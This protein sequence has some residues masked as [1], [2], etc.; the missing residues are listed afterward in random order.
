MTSSWKKA[1]ADVWL[2]RT[3]TIMVIIAIAL[4]VTGFTTV[5]SSY[6]ILMRELNDDFLATNPASATL[7][8]DKVDEALLTAIRRDPQVGMAEPRRVVM[9]KIKTGPAEWKTVEL[10]VI[11]DFK[12]IQV[13]TIQPEQG[14]WPPASGEVLIERDAF[15]VA[16]TRIGEQVTLEMS[17]GQEHTLLVSGGVHDVGQAQARMDAIVYAYITVDTLATLG[18][19][20]YLN[21]LNIV[22]AHDPFDR[23]H[24]RDVATA[25]GLTMTKMGHPVLK[26][27]V[28]VPGEHPH[29]QIMG[30]LLLV[31]AGFGILVLLLSGVLVVNLLMALMAAQIRQIGVMKAI[32]GSRWQIA[33][34]YFCQ[35]LFLGLVSL[36][37]AVPLGLWS[38]RVLCRYLGKF[39][40][41]DINSYAVP[42][43]VFMLI[44]AI[45]IV[46]PL[47][48][49]AYPI[50]KAC[51]ISVHDALYDF[52]VVKNHYKSNWF[53]QLLATIF[54]TRPAVLYT[55]RNAF[56]R[57]TRLILTLTTLTV[58]GVFFM[59]A[60]NI[61]TSII[62]TLDHLFA[63][64]D[65]DLTVTLVDM[66][67]SDAIQTALRSTAGI[68]RAETWV[69]ANGNYG[70]P[71]NDNTPE[72]HKFTVFGLPEQSQ[73]FKPTIVEGRH[74]LPGETDAIV[75]NHVVA[76]NIAAIKVGATIKLRIGSDKLGYRENAWRVV[77][78]AREPFSTPAV[79][80]PKNYF[81][82]SYPAMGN[83]VNMALTSTDAT[84]INSV[85]A[86]LE[87]NLQ[88]QGI[89][90]RG[91]FTKEKGRAVIDEHMLM[92]YVF[93]I[94]MACIIAGVGG[95][96][97]MTTMSLN[98]LERRREMGVLRAIGATPRT[99]WLIVA[100]EGVLIGLISALLVLVAAWPVS[101]ALGN[102]LVG[103]MLRS[104][105]DFRF[106]LNG[107]WIW[108]ALSVALALIASL[109]PAW[110]TS[111]SS[112]RAAIASE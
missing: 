21:Q 24:N 11:N 74:L 53:D 39:L 72:Q 65:F 81:D 76:A 25:V 82:G 56:R 48:A 112:V 23:N 57:R 17:G 51:G 97:L 94:I 107:I 30:L 4:G 50:L 64:R 41:F 93:L 103:M 105:L 40:N 33:R 75:V 91:N 73:M 35:S 55:F 88:L 43:W 20:P 13:S 28:P 83:S 6:A 49:S 37:I 84:E 10:F 3:R 59:S 110:S 67:P 58:A 60:L 109:I 8:T 95:L 62:S 98:V 77:G 36:L 90:V 29:A 45:G 7:L 31:M 101:Q 108:P 1:I 32:G 52:G 2:E 63:T 68:K 85:K 61:R 104:V 16:G 38:G 9:G 69:G 70:P 42:L 66:A 78:I 19:Q 46:V 111:T 80:I 89:H 14:A 100:G 12:H 18:E 5:M 27:D 26:T 47:L 92:I 87:H 44:A 86:S 102:M 54:A 71:L 96:G 34:I 106:N 15:Q 22:A 79:Y 99:V